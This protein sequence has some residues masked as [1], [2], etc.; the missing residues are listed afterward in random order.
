MKITRMCK[1][2]KCFCV[3]NFTLKIWQNIYIVI[4]S[5]CLCHNI[6]YFAYGNTKINFISILITI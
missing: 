4:Q 6:S 3:K 1:I 2:F 5:K